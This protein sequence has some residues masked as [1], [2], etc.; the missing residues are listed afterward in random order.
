MEICHSSDGQ[1]KNHAM[2][3]HKKDTDISLL[4]FALNQ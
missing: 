4:C 1:E 2:G 3:I